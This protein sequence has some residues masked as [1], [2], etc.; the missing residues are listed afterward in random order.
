[1]VRKKL[2]QNEFRS[3]NKRIFTKFVLFSSCKFW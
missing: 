3:Q 1:M 2:A